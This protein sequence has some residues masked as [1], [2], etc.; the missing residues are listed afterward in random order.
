MA[1]TTQNSKRIHASP[2]K[3]FKA[4]T[5]PR[6]LEHWQV[7][8]DMTGKVHEYDLREGGSYT[9]SLFYPEGEGN[10]GKTSGQEDRYTAIFEK[11]DAPYKIVERVK[12]DAEAAEFS[13]EMI[14]EI[15]LESMGDDTNVT[16]QFRNIP[17]GIS[18]KDNEKGTI[19]SLEKLAR[20]VEGAP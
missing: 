14:M 18:L 5:D 4:L 15:T 17:E 6:G 20:Y 1:R 2:E 8:G 11:L 16:F 7:P 9:M 12:F 13:E 3:I 10:P 19:S